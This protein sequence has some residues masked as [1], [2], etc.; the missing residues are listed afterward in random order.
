MRMSPMAIAEKIVAA[1]PDDETVDSVSVAPP[2]FVNIALSPGWLARQVDAVVRAG[3]CYGNV[4][5]GA[6][7]RVQ[8]E[9][10]SVNPT[11]P[12]HVGH[13]RGA[14]FGSALAEVMAAAG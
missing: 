10:V 6:G 7:K 8:L 1:M 11:G 5:A 3:A 2:G 9:F 13:A 14:V 4:D 12:I